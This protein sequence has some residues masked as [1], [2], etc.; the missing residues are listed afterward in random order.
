MLIVK[1]SMQVNELV[2]KHIIMFEL[3]TFSSHAK[4]WFELGLFA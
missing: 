2:Y 1:L 3:G 4:T